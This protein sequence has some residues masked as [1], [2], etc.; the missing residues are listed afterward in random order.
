[1]KSNL[2]PEKQNVT[3]LFR[4]VCRDIARGEA[5]KKESTPEERKLVQL[6]Q[7]FKDPC[8]TTH[9]TL[10]MDKD[11]IVLEEATLDSSGTVHYH[12]YRATRTQWAE[13][14]LRCS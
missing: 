4:M 6:A 9:V 2:E 8:S 12:T 5:L 1:M 7:D 14:W 11:D 3:D 10:H 13:A